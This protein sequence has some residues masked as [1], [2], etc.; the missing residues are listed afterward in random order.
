MSVTLSLTNLANLQNETT[1]VTAI[2]ANNAAITQAFQDV[3]ALDGTSPN[4]MEAELD[5]NSFAILN[6]PAP[7]NMSSPLR[8]LDVALLNGGGT[9]SAFTLPSG[10]D[11]GQ[12]LVKNS[13]SNYDSSWSSTVKNLTVTNSFSAPGIL[14][15]SVLNALS[16]TIG[17]TSI[18]FGQVYPTLSGPIAFSGPI[19]HTN[20]VSL[21]AALTYGGVTLSNSVTGTGSMALSISPTFTG[22]LSFGT[23]SSASLGAS[24]STVTGLAHNASPVTASDYVPYYSSANNAI[25]KITVAELVSATTAGVS[26]IASATGALTLGGDLSVTSTVLS[27]SF[28]TGDAKITFKQTADGGWLMMNDQ[29]IGDASS[30]A[31]FASSTAQALFTLFYNSPFSDS[32]VP[33]LTSTGSSTTRGAQGTASAAWAAHC[34]LTLPLQLGRS[35]AVAGSG[36]GLT[37]FTLGQNTG[38]NTHALT[39]AEAPLLT[40]TDEGHL[41][42]IALLSNTV[43]GA[44]GSAAQG[45]SQSGTSTLNTSTNFASITSNAGGGAHT[46]MQPTTFWNVMIKL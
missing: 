32:S 37:A 34:R 38:S 39:A 4:S 26:S 6:L 46:N 44:G 20:T 25:N 30:G 10:G 7:T 12:V 3:L 40:Y 21:G 27:D 18:S 2:N 35:I 14:T 1:A 45:T 16:F 33:I 36:A 29:T 13:D 31:T 28:S 11:T 41:H 24:T 22:T 5:M 43:G 42:A 17:T 9:I 15:T 8:L 23:L 19:T